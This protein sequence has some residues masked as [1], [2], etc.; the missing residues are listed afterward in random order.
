MKEISLSSWEDWEKISSDLIEKIEEERSNEGRSCSDILFRGHSCESWELDTTLERYIKKEVFFEEYNRYLLSILPA[1]ESYTGKKWSLETKP[2][3]K[4]YPSPPPNYEF[5]VYLRHHGFPSPL[6][7]WTRSP[8]IAV[9]FAFQNSGEEENVAIVT[10]V[11]DIGEGKSGCR[12]EPIICGCGPYINSHK[13]HFQQ[14]AEYT[15]CKE[16]DKEMWKYCSHEKVFMKNK[17][18][19]GYQDV[20]VKY[21][22]PSK[23]KNKALTKLDLMNINAFSLFGNEESLSKMLAYREIM[24]RN[25]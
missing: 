8:Y 22:I 9:F 18:G 15:I 21:I 3:L 19:D 12:G 20:C 10:F 2:I 13:R 6:L 14:Q 25:L 1:F 17:D 11:E 24:K 7:D 5:M 23:E 16:K 4:E